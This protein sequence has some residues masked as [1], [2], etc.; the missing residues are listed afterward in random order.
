MIRD[1][2]EKT[3]KMSTYL[4]AFIISEFECRENDD[5]TFGVC[6]RPNAIN[7][8][9]YSFKVGQKILKKFDDLFGEPYYNNIGVMHMAA[10]PGNF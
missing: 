4:V 8:T 10:I 9:K 2:F 1:H 7:Q 3:P 5:G 6:S